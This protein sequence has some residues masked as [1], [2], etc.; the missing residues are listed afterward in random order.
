MKIFIVAGGTGGHL[1]PAI[2]LAEEILSR[3]TAEV[4]FVA[5]SRKQDK[6]ILRKKNIEFQA[7]PII[8]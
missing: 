5:S 7:L 2:R 4:L 8:G 6:D 3:G 1:F